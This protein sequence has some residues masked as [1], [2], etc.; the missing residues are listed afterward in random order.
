M[1][2]FNDFRSGFFHLD[3][4]QCN[5]I[6]THRF[7]MSSLM[8]QNSSATREMDP[9]LPFPGFRASLGS[10]SFLFIEWDIFLYSKGRTSK[11]SSK[12][13]QNILDKITPLPNY[14][15]TK[16]PQHFLWPVTICFKKK[17]AGGA[18]KLHGSPVNVIG[19]GNLWENISATTP[20]LVGG[21]IQ[22]VVGRTCDP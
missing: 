20:K 16:S 10:Q 19:C 5:A 1:P 8:L 12:I 11:Y 4:K 14:I 22:P 2:L 3:P 7:R 9:Q 21:L 13:F 15:T 18:S 6:V 17:T